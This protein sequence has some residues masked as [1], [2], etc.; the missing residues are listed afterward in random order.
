MQGYYDDPQSLNVKYDLVNANGL[1]GVGIWHLLLDAGRQELWDVIGQNLLALPF[2]D[3]DDS[4][5]WSSIA[6]IAD[7]GIT[8]GCGGGKYCPAGLVTR[9]QMATFLVRALDLPPTSIDY[10]TDDETSKHEQTINRLARGRDHVRLHGDDVLPERRSS[11]AARWRA[12]SCAAST[13]R[14][15]PPTSSPMTRRTGTRSAI[16]RIAAAGITVGCDDDRYCP[17]GSVTRAQMA[18]FLRR[19]LTD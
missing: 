2:T 9:G 14:R 8:T 12:S 5:H 11:R 17:D 1:R 15:P 10:F 6:W 3:I 18:T 7:Q 4:I 16:N 13:C 19:A